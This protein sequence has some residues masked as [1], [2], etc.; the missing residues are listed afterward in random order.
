MLEFFTEQGGIWRVSDVFYAHISEDGRKQTVLEHLE[1]TARL[2]SEFAEVFGEEQMG[3]LLGLAHD[4][5]K[6]TAGFQERLNGGPKID[7]SS[8]GAFEVMKQQQFQ[9]A[10]CVSGH[11]GGIPNGGGRGDIGEQ[12]TLMGRMAKVQA[13][14]VEEYE[15]F[16]K[17]IEFPQIPLRQM[18]GKNIEA[19]CFF[20]RMLF[21]CLVDADY[22]DTERFMDGNEGQKKSGWV[23]QADMEEL[24]RRLQNY[25]SG[26]FPPKNELNKLRCEILAA[27]ITKGKEES[28][29]LFNLTVPTG[30][31]KTVALLLTSLRN[32]LSLCGES[33][34][35]FALCR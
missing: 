28:P 2:A 13:G 4:I 30:G 14:G 35:K 21:S 26:W 7:H 33:G 20:I 22:L 10:F 31:G 24:D 8:A 1:G 25:I 5:G 15:E 3:Q 17:E 32:S 27:C 29:G 12:G 18:N 16:R 11:H 34:L 9:A 23:N 6:Y 19:E